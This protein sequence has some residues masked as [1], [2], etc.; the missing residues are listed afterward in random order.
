MDRSAD[1]DV[2]VETEFQESFE[3][4]ER[5]VD[6][7]NTDLGSLGFWQLVGRI[8]ADPALERHWADVVGRIDGKAFRRRVRWGV[9]V[10]VGN[11]VLLLGTFAGSFAI[12][13]ALGTDDEVVAGA[14]LLVGGGIWSVA[15]H[16]LAHWLFGRIVGIRFTRSFL[17][18]PFLPLPTLKMDYASYL[19]T[20]A[21]GRAWMH[22]SGAIAS[23]LAPFVALAFWP[24]TEAPPWTAWGLVAFGV[25]QIATDVVFSRRLSDWKKVR[26]EWRVARDQ[27]ERV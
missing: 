14:A 27:A 18:G 15:W 12:G 19:R 22:A 17:G 8:K 2:A 1:V 16:D 21:M 7:G 13:V 9:P 6:E 26:R 24:A 3:R 20:E 4:I 25:L 10:W 11:T 5:L 23:K